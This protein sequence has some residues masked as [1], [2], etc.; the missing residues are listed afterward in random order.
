MSS[1]LAML[2][3]FGIQVVLLAPRSPIAMTLARARVFQLQ[4]DLAP[5]SQQLLCPTALVVHIS[6][7]SR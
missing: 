7:K 5:T 3:V 2:T 4:G 1:A 6:S